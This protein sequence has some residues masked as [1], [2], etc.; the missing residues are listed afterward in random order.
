MPQVLFPQAEKGQ[1]THLPC[2]DALTG[3][4]AGRKFVDWLPP[5]VVRAV[6]AFPVFHVLLFPQQDLCLLEGGLV[7]L[8]QGVRHRWAAAN[9]HCICLPAQRTSGVRALG[10]VAPLS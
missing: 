10:G 5:P 2:C 8:L 6:H 1:Q 7:A 4:R 9:L 3:P